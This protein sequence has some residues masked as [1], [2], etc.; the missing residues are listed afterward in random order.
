[1][2]NAAGRVKEE[3][4]R[5]TACERYATRNRKLGDA[6]G[7]KLPASARSESSPPP[8]RIGRVKK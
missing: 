2:A 1:V 5:S 6:F 8:N 7:L 3:I 4:D